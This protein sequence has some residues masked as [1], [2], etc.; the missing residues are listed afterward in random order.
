MEFNNFKIMVYRVFYILMCPS[1]YFLSFSFI[2]LFV[3]GLG[4]SSCGLLCFQ[5]IF[6][7]LVQKNILLDSRSSLLVLGVLDSMVGIL[8]KMTCCFAS[9]PHGCLYFQLYFIICW[10]KPNILS[11]SREIFGVSAVPG[12]IPVFFV[13][14]KGLT[15][16]LVCIHHVC[17]EFSCGSQCF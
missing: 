6:S 3:I 13:Q 8:L 7:F 16:M 14:I 11:G 4:F 10:L 1:G 17:K 9:Y 5:S 12:S 15:L 2:C